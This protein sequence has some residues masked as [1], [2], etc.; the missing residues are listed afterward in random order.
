MAKTAEDI[1]IETGQECLKASPVIVLGSG[2][3]IPVGIPSMTDLA[4][5]LIDFK[6]HKGLSRHDHESWHQFVS[7][8]QCQDLES[9]LATSSI[10]ESLSDLVIEQTWTLIK[11][12]DMEVFNKLIA[13][14]GLLPLAR[15][16]SHL[17]KST[18]RT[19][20]VVTTNYDRLAEYAADAAGYCH[21]TGFTYG[22][23]R[24][25]QATQSRISFIQG[26]RRTQTV[27]IWKVHGC[28]DWFIDS[29]E[30][31]VGVVS[32]KSVP[33]GCRPAIVT[34][35]VSK[36]AQT[37]QEPFRSV[38]TGADNALM[39]AKAYLCVGFGFNDTH[40][41]PKLMERWQQGD[42]LL[43]ILTKSLSESARV[44]LG[45]ANRQKFLALEE[46]QN[47]TIVRSNH[48][49]AG[50]VLDDID[51]WQLATF[52]DHIT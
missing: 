29:S 9:A 3:S 11:D 38:I 39:D 30:Q 20:T 41:Q 28:L 13:D 19:A 40:I 23:F 45:N 47:G 6:P 10:S 52:L 8:L 48:C 26:T 27:D 17:F 2:A 7:Q 46:A 51:L 36:Y 24:R 21:Y 34:P 14:R 22:Y 32:A 50:Q 35:G 43:V 49:P 1:A 44:M 18:N 37:H 33:A 16:Y 25:R 31:V 4:A 5:H 42:A 15:L 12:A